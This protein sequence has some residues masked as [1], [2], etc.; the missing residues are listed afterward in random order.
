MGW[1][2]AIIKYFLPYIKPDRAYLLLFCLLNVVT[3]AAN[4]VLIW[5]IGSVVSE[6]TAGAYLQL[7]NTLL[8]IACIVL[9]NQAVQFIYA[10]HFQK[11]TLRFVDRVR[12]KLLAHIMDVSFP[13]NYRF[14]RGDLI[15][16]LTG[17]VDR[18]L[19]FVVNVPLNLYS[20]VLVLIVYV[21]MLFWID[22]RL[23]L[24]A[25]TLS[26]LFFLSQRFVAPR[27]GEASRRFVQEKAN[28]LT[29][30][31]Q[32]LGNLR[33][34][35]SFNSENMMREKHQTQFNIARKWA[36]RVRRIRILYGTFLTFIVYFAGVVIVYSGIAG[37]QSGRLTVGVLISFLMYVRY[38]TFPLRNIAR[39]PIQLQA[40]RVAAERVME[41]LDTEPK[42]RQ[43]DLA[44]D[45]SLRQ[46][47]IVFDDVSFSYS[48]D[49][50]KVFNH[51]HARINAGES[52]ALVGASGS[53][54]STF[55]ALLLRFYDPQSGV[56]SIDGVDIRAVALHSLRDQISIV[57]QNPFIVSG[58]IAENLRLAKPGATTEAMI[59]ACKSSFAW[60]FIEKLK[61][62][63]N[64]PIGANGVDLSAGQIQRLALAQVFLRDTPI[65]ILDE[66]SSA[67]DSHSEKMLVEALRA[68]RKSRTTLVIAHRFSSIRTV[69][70]ILY[71]NGDGNITE[72]THEQL[73][74]SHPEYG[75][76]VNW[77]IGQP[78]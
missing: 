15:A 14:E 48:D 43:N 53:G 58:T 77:Q 44:P 25:L 3:T 50:R 75:K 1:Q 74:A 56:V 45:L 37:I 52:V 18:L 46:G 26:P 54:K 27:T 32:A 62:G 63:I 59:A 21:S 10:Y 29:I 36:L 23:T 17:D 60:E 11:V 42:V 22:R 73:M 57:W 7:Q 28:L 35:S 76:A 72:G 30:E 38:L 78:Q 8:L 5:M 9:L 41:V 12:G 19:T 69:D 68:L 34:I 6:I 70:R 67:L 55:A 40:D 61:L 20:N 24:I 2:K 64:T 39:I 51:L 31:E 16:R 4:T 71:F 47:E 49:G 13:I 65:L 66:A 33:G